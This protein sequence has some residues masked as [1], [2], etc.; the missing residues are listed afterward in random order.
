MQNACFDTKT[1]AHHTQ[2]CLG[3]YDANVD[4]LKMVLS[5]LVV[6]VECVQGRS[7]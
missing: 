2:T 1:H 7:S 6:T 4:A 5:V 3:E